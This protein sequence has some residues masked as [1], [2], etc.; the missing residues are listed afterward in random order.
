LI[1]YSYWVVAKGYG[2]P[3]QG[4]AGARAQ[5]AR[6]GGDDQRR[7]RGWVRQLTLD[8]TVAVAGTLVV[9]LAFLILG[10]E[11]LQPRGLVPEEERVAEVLGRLLGDVFGPIGFWFMIVAVFVG[12]WDTVL[13]DQ[14]GHSR[15]FGNRVRLLLEPLGL[16]GRWSDEGF[17]RRM[18]LVVVA[19][20][21]PIA[22]CWVIGHPVGLLQ[23]AGAIEAAHIPVV[24]TARHR[25]PR[26]SQLRR[27]HPPIQ[28]H[29][30]SRRR[31]PGRIQQI[32]RR[33][34]NDL[35]PMDHRP[36]ALPR[37]IGRTRRDA[38]VDLNRAVFRGS[39]AAGATSPAGRDH[40]TNVPCR[41]RPRG[42]RCPGEI[43]AVLER[44]QAVVWYCPACGDA[45]VI[46][47]WQ[48]TPL[49][50]RRVARA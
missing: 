14:D 9:T 49:D 3:T 1:W 18:F 37:R 19:V 50:R 32:R 23:V 10:A 2:M 6:L 13:S 28:H 43:V 21:A 40:R 46:L 45:G 26:W 29:H 41:C 5:L 20:G 35:E 38:G 12:F 24:A 7:L 36:A 44:D 11:L 34:R 30:Q 42:R 16:R 47:G 48:D 39:I 15:T 17:L 8:C 31:T 25:P 4:L 22:L 33:G 27:Q